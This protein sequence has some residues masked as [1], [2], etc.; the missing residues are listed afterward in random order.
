MKIKGVIFD[1]DGVIVSTDE[2]HFKAWKVLADREGIHFDR[3]INNRLRGVSRR[4]SLEIILEKANR[5]YSEN[6][7]LEMLDFKNNI[8]RNSLSELTKYD[9]LINFNELYAKLRQNKIKMA[10]GSSSKNTKTILTQIGLIDAFDAIADGNDITRSKPDPEVFLL[11][12]ERLG[13]DPKEC[14]V[15]EDAVAGIEAAK[16]GGMI[17]IAIND[18]TKCH[19]ADYKIDNLLE[20][21]NI[22]LGE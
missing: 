5:S 9:I 4:E 19:I 13:L 12:A 17:A 8:Y 10:I 21:A 15:V 3:H 2:F 22:V 20:I 1:L 16:A 11:A 18:A 14:V 7:I 6:E